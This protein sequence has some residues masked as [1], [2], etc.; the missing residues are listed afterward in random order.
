ML[1]EDVSNEEIRRALFSMRNFR[2]KGFDEFQAVF[3]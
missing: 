2:A 1:C 3:L